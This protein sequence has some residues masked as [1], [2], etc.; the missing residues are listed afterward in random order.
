MKKFHNSFM[1]ALMSLFVVI[2]FSACLGDGALPSSD[3]GASLSEGARSAA[4]ELVSHGR[5]RIAE[6]N[7]FVITD[8][9]IDVS[10][11]CAGGSVESETSGG[12][13]EP[14]LEPPVAADSSKVYYDAAYA[15]GIGVRETY[16]VT[17]SDISFADSSDL[18][19]DA[20]FEKNDEDVGWTVVFDNRWRPVDADTISLMATDGRRHE[21]DFALSGSDEIELTF[22]EECDSDIGSDN[23]DTSGGEGLALPAE[24]IYSL[25][26]IFPM[27]QGRWC[28]WDDGVI[29]GESLNEIVFNS[30]DD[31]QIITANDPPETFSARVVEKVGYPDNVVGRGTFSFEVHYTGDLR[32]ADH[33]KLSIMGE[34]ADSMLQES[35][36]RI[37][38]NGFGKIG[39]RD[40]CNPFMPRAYRG[41]GPY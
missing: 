21:F 27:L 30:V 38:F 32:T 34:A 29:P 12:E 39:D 7:N 15:Y 16:Y 37:P 8:D 41:P 25:S 28:R 22:N 17:F 19:G 14:P 11:A 5:I 1:A 26:E 20:V 18:T 10:G 24:E 40:E 4:A 6:T 3:G 33:F 35:L 31:V 9:G 2:S 23:T 13:A 36:D